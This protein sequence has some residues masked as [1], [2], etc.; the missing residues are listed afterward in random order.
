MLCFFNFVNFF[1]KFFLNP[2]FRDFGCGVCLA[3]FPTDT[4]GKDPVARSRGQEKF[5][6]RF[7][8]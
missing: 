1:L 7:L 5:P 8:H 4:N 3:I 6:D 2:W